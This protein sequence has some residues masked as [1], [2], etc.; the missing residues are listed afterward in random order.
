VDKVADT[1]REAFKGAQYPGLFLYINANTIS[2]QSR[3]I[4]RFGADRRPSVTNL[5]TMDILVATAALQTGELRNSIISHL[6]M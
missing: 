3:N 4:V 5:E 2:D 1:L 6:L